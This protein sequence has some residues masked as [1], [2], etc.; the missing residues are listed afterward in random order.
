[1]KKELETSVQKKVKR[2]V[3]SMGLK[4]LFANWAQANVDFDEINKPTVVYILPPSG[5]LRKTWHDIRDYPY[6]QIAFL[7]AADFDFDGEENDDRVEAMKT[8]ASRFIKEVDNSGMFEPL[9]ENIPYQTLYDTLDENLT[10]VV[11]TIELREI[12][13]LN[14]CG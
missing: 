12:Q 6:S 1:M 3:E 4:Y 11:I 13:G 5:T 2:I 9:G 8:L 7:C 10:G 14:I